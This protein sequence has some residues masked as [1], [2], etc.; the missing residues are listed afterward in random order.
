[1]SNEARVWTVGALV[2]ALVTGVAS[3]FLYDWL[4]SAPSANGESP[5]STPEVPTA[6]LVS[7]SPAGSSTDP[8][9]SGKKN[10]GSTSIT[11]P[12]GDD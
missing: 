8:K 1:M 3:N 12:E 2:F 9:G 7:P 6:R 11:A 4:K 10:V 5:R